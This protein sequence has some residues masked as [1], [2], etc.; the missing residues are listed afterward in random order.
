MFFVEKLSKKLSFGCGVMVC[1]A[2]YDN[3]HLEMCSNSDVLTPVCSHCVGLLH[4]GP[5]LN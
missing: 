5:G 4:F 2:V 1:F 3:V